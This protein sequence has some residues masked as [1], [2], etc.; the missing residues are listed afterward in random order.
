MSTN[1]VLYADEDFEPIT[2]IKLQ[3][4]TINYLKRYKLVRLFLMKLPPISYKIECMPVSIQ[5]LITLTI[6]AEIVIRNEKEHII[7]FTGD[8]ESA[9]LLRCIFLPGQQAELQ[10]RDRK[11]F[12]Q[13]VLHAL[14]K[15]GL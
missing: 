7:L 2:I 8:E 11:A 4:H 14:T 9:L 1:V 10:E 3:D 12:E 15:I 6:K 5:D 13:R